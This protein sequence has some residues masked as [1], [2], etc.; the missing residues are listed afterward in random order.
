MHQTHLHGDLDSFRGKDLGS[1]RRAT[2][3]LA[4]V[5]CVVSENGHARC[6][7]YE[8]E[9]LCQQLSREGIAVIVTISIPQHVRDE[10]R[11]MRMVECRYGEL[12]FVRDLKAL[13]V[14]IFWKR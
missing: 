14:H 2:V 4:F 11:F 5:P 7:S 8:A 10:I 12:E 6:W 3:R 9:T 1:I 13:S